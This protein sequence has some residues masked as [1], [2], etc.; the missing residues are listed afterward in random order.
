MERRRL[1][2][3][4]GPPDLV[5]KLKGGVKGAFHGCSKPR[6]ASYAGTN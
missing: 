1:R 5:K 6:Q 3:W 4:N 2:I